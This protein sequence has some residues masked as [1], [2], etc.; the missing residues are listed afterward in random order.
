MLPQPVRDVQ[1]LCRA[2]LIVTRKTQSE[3]E[4]FLCE[5]WACERILWC[6]EQLDYQHSDLPHADLAMLGQMFGVWSGC[7]YSEGPHGQ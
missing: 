7:V 5:R 2:F 3:R 1:V 6:C 4:A